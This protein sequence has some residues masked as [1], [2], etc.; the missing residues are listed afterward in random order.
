[1][2]PT[3][4]V[5]LGGWCTAFVFGAIAGRSNFCTMG[6]VADVV[7]MGHWGRA[8]SWM[9][10]LAV[11][12]LGANLMALAG[13]IDLSQSVYHRPVVPWLSLVL[14]G[15]VFGVG[16]TLAGGC[17]NRNLVRLG[18]GSMRSLVV[19][20]FLGVSGY[21]TLKGIF[22][23]WRAV[24]LDPVV[25]DVSGMG[26]RTLS[27]PSLL[28]KGTGWPV[29][30]ALLVSLMGVAGGLLVFVLRDRDFRRQTGQVGSAAMLGLLICAGWFI[31]GHL[32]YGENEE[33]L[34][35]VYFATNTRTLESLT[36]VGPVAYSL[37]LLML[38]SD[39]SL[40]ATFGITSVLGAFMGSLA[41]SLHQKSFHLEGFA[42]T[43]DLGRHLT[44]AVLMGVGGV[45]SIGCT[46]GQ[47]LSGLSTL[48]PASLLAVAGI[49]AGSALTMKWLARDDS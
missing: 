9:L 23:Q 12:V 17:P 34:E 27:L 39:K 21:M 11:A 45:T 22:A 8:R 5:L 31:T 35:T 33:T 4:T 7:N 44:G 2:T 30:Q 18:Q 46:I 16:M 25:L 20:V 15:A 37:E 3:T 29:E 48:A 28:S 42:S 10:A 38:W 13:W 24:Y 19:L 1:M 32:G 36:F 14:G 49:V 43:D 41:V 26:L 6:A 40:H 47:G